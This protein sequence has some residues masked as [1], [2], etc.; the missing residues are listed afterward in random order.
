MKLEEIFSRVREYANKLMERED[1][2]FFHTYAYLKRYVKRGWVKVMKLEALATVVALHL[3]GLP[4]TIRTFCEA[5]YGRYT[6]ALREHGRFYLNKLVGYRILLPSKPLKLRVY[7]K[8]Y[9]LNPTFLFY[10]ERPL[11]QIREI[12]IREM[13]DKE[14]TDE[15]KVSR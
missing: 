15:E 14:K 2:L 12:S 11:K 3:S 10:L 4:I 5:Y 1:D 6:P 8:S 9:K 13:G 7:Q